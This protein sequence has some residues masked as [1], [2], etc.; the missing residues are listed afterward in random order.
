MEQI[1]DNTMI[2]ADIQIH[3]KYIYTSTSRLIDMYVK[4]LVSGLS[5]IV[6]LLTIHTGEGRGGYAD[7]GYDD[8][9]SRQ[10]N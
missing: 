3:N 2:M 4:D 7:Y 10:G 5:S 6:E 8:K 1:T 9:D